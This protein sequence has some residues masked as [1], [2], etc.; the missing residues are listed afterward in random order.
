MSKINENNRGRIVG[1]KFLKK[2]MECNTVIIRFKKK[3]EKT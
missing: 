1:G 3:L 2:M